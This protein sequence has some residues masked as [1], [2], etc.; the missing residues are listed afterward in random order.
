MQN[1]EII[2]IKKIK[3]VQKDFCL[4]WH[5]TKWNISK[6]W[7]GKMPIAEMQVLHKDVFSPEQKENL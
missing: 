4:K 1:R 6:R 5:V 7:S 2:E 3:E